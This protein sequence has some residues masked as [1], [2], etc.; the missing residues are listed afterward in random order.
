M[1]ALIL[2]LLRNCESK[3]AF[4]RCVTLGSGKNNNVQLHA[5][6]LPAAS[7]RKSGIHHGGDSSGRVAQL[8]EQL[9]LNQ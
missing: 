3:T 6:G 4:N 2:M 9:T 7:Q 1:G 5:S 8:A